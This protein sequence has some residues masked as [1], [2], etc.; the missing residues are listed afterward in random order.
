M[1]STNLSE[2]N[3]DGLLSKASSAE[4]KL[5]LSDQTY[6]VGADAASARVF[7][8]LSGM[9]VLL[10]GHLSTGVCFLDLLFIN[11]F[12]LA[13]ICSLYL[14]LKLESKID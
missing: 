11:N 1:R 8:V 9:R 6:R 7:S 10:V 14:A 4:H 12:T 13:S 3:L 5:V 2:A